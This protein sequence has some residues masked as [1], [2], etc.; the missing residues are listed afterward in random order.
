MHARVVLGTDV[1]NQKGNCDRCTQ[2]TFGQQMRARYGANP[3]CTQPT[4]RMHAT[5]LISNINQSPYNLLSEFSVFCQ[6]IHS[7][8]CN[9]PTQVCIENSHEQVE[10]DRNGNPSKLKLVIP[11]QFEKRSR[12]RMEKSNS[13]RQELVFCLVGS[14]VIVVLNARQKTLLVQII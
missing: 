9:H 11:V 7:S 5:P 14:M 12:P 4:S 6:P 13:K 10:I 1:R 3:G 2:R 8:G